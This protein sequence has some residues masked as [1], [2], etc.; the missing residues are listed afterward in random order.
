MCQE[1]GGY[2][3][4]LPA[5]DLR[6]K[7]GILALFTLDPREGLEISS[8]LGDTSPLPLRT[9]NNWGRTIFQRKGNCY[10]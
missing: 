4:S 3:Y 8:D 7:R 9:I 6:V 2:F 10:F 5:L 1:K